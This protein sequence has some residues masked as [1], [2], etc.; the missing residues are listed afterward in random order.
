MAPQ[1]DASRASMRIVSRA[2][3]ALLL[4]C[5][6]NAWLSLTRPQ[7]ADPYE[8]PYHGWSYWSLN[9][10]RH[11]DSARTN[12]VLLGSSLVVAAIAECDATYKNQQLDLCFYRDAQ[13]FD[14]RLRRSF[15]FNFKTLDLSTPGQIPSD[16][17]LTLSAALSNGIKPG[18]VIYGIAPRDFID[19]TLK[20]PC[21]TEPFHYLSRM[22]PID[23]CAEDVFKNPI[24][25]LDWCLQKNVYLYRAA[26]DCMLATRDGSIRFLQT[27]LARTS[28]APHFMQ[29]SANAL[30]P[31]YQP[32]NI[33]P[34]TNW[35][36]VAHDRGTFLDNT[37]DYRNRYKNP[38]AGKYAVQMR[39]LHR[40]IRLC[41]ANDIA[42]VLV[43][44]PITRQNA[45]LLDANWRRRYSND[46]AELARV[47]KIAVLDQCDFAQYSLDDYRDTV[48][49]NAFG[50]RKFIDRL[51]EKMKTE[52]FSNQALLSAENSV[53]KS[54]AKRGAIVSIPGIE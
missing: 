24:G 23:D 44:M 29:S 40:V 36:M 42:I 3:T 43:N 38:D 15:A 6:V 2:L 50:A 47:H 8:F 13:Y 22:V 17:Y 20:D 34:G 25:R 48:H 1:N 49:L 18:A 4:F 35:A 21:D 10:I 45:D 9:A 27:A 41:Q 31:D 51:V 54:L 26:A 11:A 52:P 12:V 37:F 19:Q 30:L 16:A 32:F 46:L 39:F 5:A 14:D 33:L 7:F 53:K 28:I